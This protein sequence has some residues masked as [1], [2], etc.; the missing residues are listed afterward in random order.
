LRVVAS[1]SPADS[2]VRKGGWPLPIYTRLIDNPVRA[3]VQVQLAN[4]RAALVFSD[5]DVGQAVM[6]GA[7]ASRAAPATIRRA[8]RVIEARIAR[9][10]HRLTQT[11]AKVP[12]TTPSGR[13]RRRA[14]LKSGRH[15]LVT[16]VKLATY[17]AERLLARR[18]FQHYQDPRDWLTVFRSLLQ[19]PGVLRQ[20]ADGTIAVQLQAPD[21]SRIRR[22][23]VSFLAEINDMHP[24]MFG[25]GP[26][27]RF[28][29]QDRQPQLNGSPSRFTEF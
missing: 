9:L 2:G 17:N 26:A 29:V 25:T 21:Q 28:E 1:D 5:A 20:E 12:T 6:A 11:P 15:D 23:L 14:T 24:R 19:L 27:R 18:F 22:A 10:E 4:A 7:S 13:R 16:G 8:A 3:R